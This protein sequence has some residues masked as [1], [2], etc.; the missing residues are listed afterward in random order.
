MSDEQHLPWSDFPAPELEEW[1]RAAA[2]PKGKSV[3]R[4]SGATPEG[5]EERPIYRAED[6][7]E[8]VAAAGL[9]GASPFTRGAQALGAQGWLLVVTPEARGAQ[10]WR[11]EALEAVRGGAG[12]LELFMEMQELDFA[13]DLARALEGIDLE[14][15]ALHLCGLD[16][17][18]VAAQLVAARPEST[19]ARVVLCSDPLGTLASCWSLRV[20]LAAHYDELALLARW[21]RERAPGWIVEHILADRWHEAGG[22]AV[23]EL[24][25]GVAAGVE[26]LRA[27]IERGLAPDEAA[28]SLA[29]TF[30]VGTRFFT[31]VAKLRAARVLWAAVT[32]AF[33]CSVPARAMTLHARS[34]RWSQTRRDPWVN[35]IRGAVEGFA[36]VAGGAEA[37]ELEP[38]DSRVGVS[39]AAAQRHARGTQ[40]LLRHEAR[41][42]RVVDP[43]GG[44]YYVEWLTDALARAAWAELQRVEAAGGL[45]AAL[46]QRLPQEELRQAGRRR[47]ERVARLETPIVGVS[48]YANLA[49]ELPDRPSRMRAPRS[50]P[51]SPPLT[52][53]LRQALAPGGRDVARIEA[54]IA[55]ARAGVSLDALTGALRDGLPEGERTV[56]L[57]PQPAAQAFEILRMLD[58]AP[59]V[60]A[61]LGP[62]AELRERVEFARGTLATGN[63]VAAGGERELSASAAAEE[64]QRAGARVLALCAADERYPELVPAVASALEERGWGAA[65]VVAGR[66]PADAAWTALP[67]V[68]IHRGCDLPAALNQLQEATMEWAMAVTR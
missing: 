39:D 66:R 37:I 49:E 13:A 67:S 55:A 51:A 15:V 33:G 50:L 62:P 36:A 68:F 27:L 65:I 47:A 35:L 53:E 11:A 34:S 52:A 31:E 22:T 41:L 61:C 5:L 32:E 28:R 25:Y 7:S 19:A 44:A 2:G 43:A 42:D 12:A 57:D 26:H 54:A 17:L 6:A 46:A 14:R 10:A 64:C 16:S 3:A 4:L 20:P 29:F 59:A 56:G 58:P 30:S 45:A 9:P 40:H 63:F 18:A 23:H 24:A 38:Y 21:A 1:R 8:A 60:L 48:R